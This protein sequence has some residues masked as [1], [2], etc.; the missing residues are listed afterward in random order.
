M[1]QR[2]QPFLPVQQALAQIF[3][4]VVWHVQGSCDKDRTCE[5]ERV[6]AKPSRALIRTKIGDGHG[7]SVLVHVDVHLDCKVE[8][9]DINMHLP[10]LLPKARL[11]PEFERQLLFAVGLAFKCRI[12]LNNPLTK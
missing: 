3:A 2:V 9:F 11:F 4:T 10:L 1:R 6:L 5:V 12:G 7:Q 8:A